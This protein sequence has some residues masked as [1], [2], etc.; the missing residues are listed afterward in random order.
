MSTGRPRSSSRETLAEAACELFLERGYDSTTVGDIAA[1]AGVSRSSFFN[2]FGSKS[3]ILW[4]GLDARLDA[5]ELALAEGGGLR[6]S[7]V[8]LADG[9]APDALALALVNARAMGLEPELARE[10]AARRGRLAAAVAGRLRSDG[11]AG[12]EAEVAGAAHGGA[13]LAAIEEWA[14]RGAGNTALPE[15]LAAALAAAAPTLRG[16]VR[17]LRVI[18]RAD[19]FDGAVAFYRDALGMTEQEAFEGDG[20]ARVMILDAGRATLELS[21]AAQIDL[22]DRV[23]TDGDAPSEAIR[24]ALEV[25]DAVEAT[26]AV[27]EAGALLEATPRETPWRSL[28]ARV[29]GAAGLQLTLFEELGD[30]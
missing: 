29:R 11:V 27:L 6:A 16:P 14:H 13:V 8:A 4:A 15:V 12:L 18:A 17:Q 2:Y 26:A 5:V 3:D 19:H 9:F 30:R 22:I 25:D 7:L 23:E 1:R 21:N 10:S 28:N 24:V 20:G